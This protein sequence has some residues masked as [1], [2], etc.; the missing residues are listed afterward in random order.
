M[1]ETNEILAIRDSICLSGDRLL[2]A[3]EG[4]TAA[5]LNWTPPAEG[6]NSIYAIVSHAMS[7]QEGHILRRIFGQEIELRAGAG[8]GARGDSAEPLQERWK[9]LRPRIREILTNASRADLDRDC[10]HPRL[11]TMSGWE[12][13]LLVDRHN[14]EHIGHTE[15]T[16]DLAK[17]AGV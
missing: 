7:A 2:K 12:M 11:G 1:T 14:S 17:A 8:W 6:A 4:L 13:L 5:Q 16:R 10:E 15:L 9:A 3:T